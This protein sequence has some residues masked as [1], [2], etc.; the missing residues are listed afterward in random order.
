MNE[1]KLPQ[2][3]LSATISIGGSISW[4]TNHGGT[5]VLIISGVAGIY[6]IYAT[7]LTVQVKKLERARL[8]RM[9]TEI[10]I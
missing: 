8:Q 9:D 1:S 5:I 2:A 4:L 10:G 3:I 6:S 7:R